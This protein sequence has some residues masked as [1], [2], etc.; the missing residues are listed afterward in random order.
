MGH[1][2]L[3]TVK[4]VFPERIDKATPATD[5]PE[6]KENVSMAV[7]NGLKKLEEDIDVITF[8]RTSWKRTEEEMPMNVF[9]EISKS[10][11]TTSNKKLAA[12]SATNLEEG[13]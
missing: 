7:K 9:E 4:A 1:S 10:V 6:D 11:S 2:N 13:G 8:I 12:L 3:L 5:V